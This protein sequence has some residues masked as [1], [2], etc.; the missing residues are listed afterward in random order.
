MMLLYGLRK[1]KEKGRM[2]RERTRKRKVV[3]GTGDQ[4]SSSC[5]VYVFYTQ[6]HKQ[7]K[8]ATA[9]Q[10]RKQTDLQNVISDY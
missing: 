2:K 8:K 7:I 4:L 5:P 1:G 6:H 3:S 9:N 10:A